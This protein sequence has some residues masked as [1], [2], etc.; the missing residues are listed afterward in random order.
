MLVE[1]V[2]LKHIRLNVLSLK[3]TGFH[4]GVR[5]VK[6]VAQLKLFYSMI[7]AVREVANFHI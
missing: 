2:L 6:Q 7:I 1:Q 4:V 5:T 3:I